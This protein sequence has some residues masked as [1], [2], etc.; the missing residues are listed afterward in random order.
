MAAASHVTTWVYGM[1]H[2][3]PPYTGSSPFARQIDFP[4]PVQMSFPTTGTNF[5]PT[6]QGI[7]FGNYYVYSVI[8]QV[9]SGNNQ[10]SAKYASGDSVAT[11]ATAAG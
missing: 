9:A 3:G 2:G 7:P 5:S 4:T 6:S 10:L 8:E 11:L 1:I